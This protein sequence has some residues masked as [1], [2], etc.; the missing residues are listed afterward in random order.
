MRGR[1]DAMH[2]DPSRMNVGHQSEYSVIKVDVTL[3][4]A[5]PI[6]MVVGNRASRSTDFINHLIR[7]S[8]KREY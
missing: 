8:G 4:K 3:K 6:E 5:M 2:E 7:N 1:S